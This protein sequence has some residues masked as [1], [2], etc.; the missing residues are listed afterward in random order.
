M[1]EIYNLSFSAVLSK[2]DIFTKTFFI[3]IFDII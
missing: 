2:I 1:K 3:F